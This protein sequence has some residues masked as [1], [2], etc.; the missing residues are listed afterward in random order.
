M[1]PFLIL[2]FAVN[3]FNLTRYLKPKYCVASVIAFFVML[4]FW[5]KEYTV[6]ISGVSIALG[7]P[8]FV[9]LFRLAIGIVSS[10]AVSSVFYYL[11]Q[12]K[13]TWIIFKVFQRA[14]KYSFEIY[15]FH[16]AIIIRI[17]RK[18]FSRLNL[19]GSVIGMNEFVCQFILS[20]VVAI[21]IVEVC[22]LTVYITGKVKTANKL[23]WGNWR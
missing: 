12:R 14:G 16:S 4:I 20:P 22:I 3:E 23:L 11:Y 1:Y 2:G 8:L 19:V 7:T 17:L 5:R 6:Y 13:G 18:I 9:L 21:I 10:I 15:I